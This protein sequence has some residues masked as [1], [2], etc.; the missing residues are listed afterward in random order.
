M[1]FDEALSHADDKLRAFIRQDKARVV[2]EIRVM[3]N[4][5]SAVGFKSGATLR[6]TT[7]IAVAAI[8]RRIAK[9]VSTLKECIAGVSPSLVDTKPLQPTLDQFLPESLD[10]LATHIHYIVNLIGA[11]IT[12]APTI[13]PVID[14]RKDGLQAAQI[15]LQLYVSSIYRAPQRVVTPFNILIA[16]LGLVYLV[17]GIQWV[18]KPT[19]PFEPWITLTGIV[20]TCVAGIAVWWRSVKNR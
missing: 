19:G 6:M 17:L 20:Y 8:D 7:R 13:N 4:Q 11:P 1:K 3:H 2:E 9:V 5:Q 14:R 15:D 12:L 16:A 10:D 18:I